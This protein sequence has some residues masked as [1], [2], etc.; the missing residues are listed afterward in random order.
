MKILNTLTKHYNGYSQFHSI[1]SRKS[2]EVT[3]VDIYLSF[4]ED[5]RVESVAILQK[6]VQEDLKSQLGNCVVNIIVNNE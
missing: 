1:S 6:Q 3:M 5:A 2:G 4:E